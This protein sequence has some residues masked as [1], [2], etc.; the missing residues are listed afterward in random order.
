VA[1]PYLRTRQHLLEPLVRAGYQ[2][3]FNELGRIFTE[4]ELAAALPGHVATIA[5][6]E[7]YNERTLSQG[8]ELKVVA[9]FGV[10]HDRIDIGAASRHRV[11]VAM[12]F[13][14][15]HEAVADHAFALMAAAAHRLIEYDQR[16]KQGT[17][18]SLFHGTLH[19]ATAGIVGFGRI[20]RAFA[21]RCNGFAMDVLVSD[22]A[23]D[24]EA[25]ARVGARLVSLE[26]LL[27]RSDFVS[28]H[29]PLS[30]ETA[31]LIDGPRLALMKPTA[32]LINTARGG[33]VDEPA[34]VAA[35]QDRRIAAAGLDVFAV[36]PLRDSPLQALD[37]A[38]LTPHVAGVSEWAV[39]TMASRCV[40]TILE[41]GRGEMP[42]GNLILNPEVLGRK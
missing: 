14:S 24:A 1:V 33:V 22:P 15:N 10:G 28:I 25:V 4:D 18:G 9:R 19:R 34:L 16:V 17:W 21:R 36:E 6:S 5:S 3:T 31:R 29:V 37:N 39:E 42:D 26:E 38:V 40:E 32:I 2:L 20:G 30:P 8:R 41:I 27:R 7:P 13:G 12:A 23:M 35:L 11:A